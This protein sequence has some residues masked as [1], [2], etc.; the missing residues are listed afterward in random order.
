M[1]Q[2]YRK[3]LQAKKKE[4]TGKLAV[5][6]DIAVEPISEA[7]D[8]V[9]RA[10]EREFAISRLDRDWQTLRAVDAALAR[11]ADKS[12]GICLRCEEDISPKRLN[13]IPWAP[14]CITC[15]EQADQA[16]ETEHADL[17][18]SDAA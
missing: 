17:A 11:I 18:F 10:S 7:I 4:L 16:R 5:R 1:T 15:Q 12:Y 13:A 9:Q 2:T 14:L 6:E 8:Q 3:A